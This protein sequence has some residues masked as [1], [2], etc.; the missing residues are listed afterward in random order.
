VT[1]D[2][3][4]NPKMEPQAGDVFH[5]WGQNFLII[6][7]TQGCV[8]IG[9]SLSAHREWVGLLFFREWAANAEIVHDALEAIQKA[10]EER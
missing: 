3:V 6:R 4:R 7:H 8:F 5:K 1:A 9:P 2:K 10:K